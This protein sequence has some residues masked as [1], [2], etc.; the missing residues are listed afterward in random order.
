MVLLFSFHRSARFRLYIER[1]VFLSPRLTLRC[2]LKRT[3]LL[4]VDMFLLLGWFIRVMLLFCVWRLTYYLSLCD[5]HELR[6]LTRYLMY[7]FRYLITIS[8]LLTLS[9]TTFRGM[10]SGVMQLLCRRTSSPSHP[11]KG[12]HAGPLRIIIPRHMIMG[13]LLKSIWDVFT[14]TRRPC[15]FIWGWPKSIVRL[16]T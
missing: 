12:V 7:T 13:T 14:A 6:G 9:I 11:E 16:A 15:S 5:F 8:I 2:F 3:F 10:F 4:W 1:S